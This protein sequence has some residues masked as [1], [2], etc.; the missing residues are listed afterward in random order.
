MVRRA[1]AV[2]GEQ[3]L[4]VGVSQQLERT[5][6]ATQR[7][8]VQYGQRDLIVVRPALALGNEVDLLISHAPYAHRVVAPQQL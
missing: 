4:G 5:Q 2:Q 3:R 6:L 7:R 8:L 1:D